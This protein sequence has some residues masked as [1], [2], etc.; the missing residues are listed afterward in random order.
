MVAWKKKRAFASSRLQLKGKKS[1]RIIRK[2]HA[3]RP[4]SPRVT[5]LA[6]SCDGFTE[7][8][9]SALLRENTSEAVCWESAVVKSSNPQ[10]PSTQRHDSLRNPPTFKRIKHWSFMNIE[11]L[12]FEI[13]R[14]HLILGHILELLPILL[15]LHLS[16]AEVSSQDVMSLTSFASVVWCLLNQVSQQVHIWHP[17]S[18]LS[19]S[20]CIHLFIRRRVLPY[21][22]GSAQGFYLLKGSFS[23]WVQGLFFSD[24]CE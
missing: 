7:K 13:K 15:F 8:R 12:Y 2:L 10:A 21:G 5:L 16:T 9:G 4:V 24:G 3:D 6:R 18:W 22:P 20:S 1:K 17:S 14:R 11:K 23:F 19:F